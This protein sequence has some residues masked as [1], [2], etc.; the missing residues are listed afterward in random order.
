MPVDE[1]S[2]S[3]HP[4]YFGLGRFGAFLYSH[5]QLRRRI[6]A[7]KGGFK[8]FLKLIRPPLLTKSF[9]ERSSL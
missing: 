3:K 5:A 9:H 7:I 8:P 2:L 4:A 6:Q 1:I